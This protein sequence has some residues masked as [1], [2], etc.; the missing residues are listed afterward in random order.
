MKTTLKQLI[1]LIVLLLQAELQAQPK[2]LWQPTGLVTLTNFGMPVLELSAID[3]QVALMTGGA[4]GI[5]I[6]HFIT[7]VYG[8]WLI[9]EN[10]FR[11]ENQDL[12]LNF[13]HGGILLGYQAP[14]Q[15]KV[16]GYGNLQIGWGRAKLKNTTNRQVIFKDD[17]LLV[18]NPVLGVHIQLIAYMKLHLT[19]GYRWVRGNALPIPGGTM[20]DSWT[21]RCTV[22]FHWQ[23]Q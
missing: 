9:S 10:R 5:G 19:G 11:V 14:T 15:G 8:Q 13:G 21:I 12:K 18:V 17:N 4:T 7:A 23:D 20:L 6:N 16:H 3:G 2:T 1:L 22:V